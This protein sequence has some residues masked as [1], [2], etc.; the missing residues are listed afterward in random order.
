LYRTNRYYIHSRRS[1]S[2]S[3]W[4]TDFRL[5]SWRLPLY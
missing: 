2:G 5:S 1:Q 3:G 4:C